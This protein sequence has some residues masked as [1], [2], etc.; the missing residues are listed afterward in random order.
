MFF[1][2]IQNG[3]AVAINVSE[4]PGNGGG[5][6]G[7]WR[8][9]VMKTKLFALLLLAGSALFAG[10]RVFVG[11]GVGGYPIAVA[12]PPPPVV[13]YYVP[14]APAP[15]YAW[16]GGYYYPYGARYAWRPGYWAPRPFVGAYWVGPRWYGG[17]YYHGYWGRR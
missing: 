5:M 11:V 17:H 8:N 15:N 2:W 13:S 12:P 16:V 7:S 14:P 6:K 10:P 4:P 9:R 3:K 1:N